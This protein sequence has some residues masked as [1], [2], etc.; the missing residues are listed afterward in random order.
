MNNFELLGL[1]FMIDENFDPWLIEVNT[2]PCL[3]MS[4]SLLE[5]MMPQLIDNVFKQ[6]I[7]N[8]GFVSILYFHLLRHGKQG[9]S[10][11]LEIILFYKIDFKQFSMK[12][13]ME[14][15]YKPFIKM[16]IDLM[17]RWARLS[18]I[19]RYLRMMAMK[20]GRMIANETCLYL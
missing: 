20:S 15:N 9:K 5:K 12:S 10:S 11:F 17:K 13:L 18:K 14:N 7:L 4:C 2:N 3:E 6:I 8:I 1:D 19:T 16:E